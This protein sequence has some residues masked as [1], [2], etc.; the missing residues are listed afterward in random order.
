[1]PQV[2]LSTLAPSPRSNANSKHATKCLEKRYKRYKRYNAQNATTLQ[3]S[4]RYKTPQVQ[5]ST[6]APSPRSN[7]NS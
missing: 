5:L 6:L 4:K 2:Q 3:R 1:M 7:A